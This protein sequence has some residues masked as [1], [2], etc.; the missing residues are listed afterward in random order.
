M[1]SQGRKMANKSKDYGNRSIDGKTA[2]FKL[3]SE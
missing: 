3:D 2:L 1:T